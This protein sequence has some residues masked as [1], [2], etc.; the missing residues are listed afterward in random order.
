MGQQR[1]LLL[2][3]FA[4]HPYNMVCYLKIPIIC[5]NGIGLMTPNVGARYI[6]P[7]HMTHY[8]YFHPFQF[9][10]LAKLI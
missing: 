1:I 4:N 7:L 10:N 8:V 3:R 9:D 2:G 5:P 6:V